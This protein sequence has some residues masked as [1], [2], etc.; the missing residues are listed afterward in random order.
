MK[1]DVNCEEKS[2]GSYQELVS[3]IHPMKYLMLFT[4]WW[5]TE[6][7]GPGPCSLDHNT[8]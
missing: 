6:V 4:R 5:C 7:I 8:G 1:D 2:N 3:V